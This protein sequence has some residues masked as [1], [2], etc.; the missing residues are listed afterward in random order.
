MEE[1]MEEKE[2]EKEE[3]EEEEEDR[4]RRRGRVW[5]SEAELER[6]LFS[7]KILEGRKAPF[8]PGRRFAC[9]SPPKW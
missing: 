2:T 5:M 1:E 4:G 9:P 8:F 7:F 6:E 3:K